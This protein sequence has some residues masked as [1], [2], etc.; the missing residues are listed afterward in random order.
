MSA[1]SDFD[2][3]QPDFGS[4]SRSTRT[5]PTQTQGHHQKRRTRVSAPHEWMFTHNKTNRCCAA[6][7]SPIAIANDDPLGSSKEVTAQ[8]KRSGTFQRCSTYLAVT[9]EAVIDVRAEET[10][11]LDPAVLNRTFSGVTGIGLKL[12]LAA[13]VR[14]IPEQRAQS[15]AAQPSLL[16]PEAAL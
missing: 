5:P 1:A 2:F 7:F 8:S 15:L 4:L 16:N 6:A 14:S 11:T 9:A 13:Q 10:L 3:L 12:G